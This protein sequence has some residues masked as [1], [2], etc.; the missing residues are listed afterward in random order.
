[1]LSRIGLKR[2]R[3]RN[4]RKWLHSRG[5]RPL[6]SAVSA[7]NLYG[8]N[9]AAY[10]MQIKGLEDW[11]ELVQRNLGIVID[12]LVFRL[13]QFF[14]E[15][16]SDA[17]DERIADSR[18]AGEIPIAPRRRGNRRSQIAQYLRSARGLKGKEEE[19]AV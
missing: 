7:G 9:M 13:G 18:L 1:M 2:R 8:A 10:D 17:G 14:L 15:G 5:L 16:A 4:G 6:L 3:Q 19:R 12:P 11:D